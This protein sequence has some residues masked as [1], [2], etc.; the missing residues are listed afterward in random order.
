M[1]SVNLQ[2]ET[3]RELGKLNEQMAQSNNMKAAEIMAAQTPPNPA[4][5]SDSFN[6]KGPYV[7]IV[8]DVEV[9]FLD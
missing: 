9:E 4:K 1:D 5:L 8:D 6:D 3:N 7:P 2:M